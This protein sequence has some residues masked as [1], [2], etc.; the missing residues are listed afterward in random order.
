[1]LPRQL[2]CGVY[3]DGGETYSSTSEET[4]RGAAP[5]LQARL[6][7]S[8]RDGQTWV[9]RRGSGFPYLETGS[10]YSNSTLTNV[11]ASSGG[12]AFAKRSQ[13]KHGREYVELPRWNCRA[14]LC[15]QK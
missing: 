1:M 8:A 14:E 4:W 5:Y 6:L 9:Q 2:R 13:C 7:F 3:R 12:V 10:I 11:T 15:I